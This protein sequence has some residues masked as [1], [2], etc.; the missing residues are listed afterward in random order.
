[1]TNQNHLKIVNRKLISQ[2]I[3][4]FPVEKHN[5][6]INQIWV[7]EELVTAYQIQYQT[8]EEVRSVMDSLLASILTGK[9]IDDQPSEI[10][11]DA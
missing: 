2:I 3:R 7:W 8:N 1:M 4:N 6:M 10:D 5:L 11:L 9:M